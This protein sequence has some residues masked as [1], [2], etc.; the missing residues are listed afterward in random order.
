M[1]GISHEA[2]S[3]AGVW[4][5]GKL[6]AIYDDNG[7]SIDGEAGH[8]FGDDTAQRFAAYGWNVLGPID[9]HDVD[10]V[11]RALGSARYADKPTLIIA[12][13]VIG[14]GAP[15]RAGTEKAHGEPLGDA[16]IAATRAALG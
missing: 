12:R 15:T 1:E 3:L 16:E 5:L 9:G 4:K 7:I 2:A 13:T 10:A 6:V 8:W 11:D 14:H